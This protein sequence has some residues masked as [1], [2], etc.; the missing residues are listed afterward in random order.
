M[1]VDI[2]LYG[3]DVLIKVFD[4]KIT[5]ATENSWHA[6]LLEALDEKLMV[7]L[8]TLWHDGYHAFTDNLLFAHSKD[9]AS[10]FIAINEAANEFVIVIGKY[11]K[12]N[13]VDIVHVCAEA[14]VL[15]PHISHHD[16]VFKVG[17]HLLISLLV[18]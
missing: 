5:D 7:K 9:L 3:Y 12:A 8:N 1:E 18:V 17:Y 4:E 16:Q 6:F 15:L 2:E 14:G 10:Y 11:G 13:I